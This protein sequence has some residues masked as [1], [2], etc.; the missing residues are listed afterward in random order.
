MDRSHIVDQVQYPSGRWI[1]YTPDVADRLVTIGRLT[2]AEALDKTCW[3]GVQDAPQGVPKQINLGSSLI[4]RWAFSTT[5][6]QPKLQ[7]RLWLR[8]VQQSL[9]V[10]PHRPGHGAHHEAG[11]DKLVLEQQVPR[12]VAGLVRYSYD[13]EG[14]RV[15]KEDGSVTTRYVCDANGNLAAEYGGTMAS[16]AA[17]HY[18]TTD[19]LGSTRL[20]YFGARYFSGTMG[21]FTE[22]DPVNHPTKS[23]YG[24]Q[25]FLNEPHRWNLFAYGLGN[26]LRN[27]DPDGRES[28][29]FPLFNGKSHRPVPEVSRPMTSR[30]KQFVKGMR[31]IALGIG[32]LET[33]A[34]GDIPGSALGATLVAN[35][36]IGATVTGVSGL[37]DVA[38]ATAG[39][40]VT[41]ATEVLAATSNLRGLTVTAVTGGNLDVDQAASTATSVATLARNPEAALR[42]P[43]TVAKAANTGVSAISLFSGALS[44]VAS[45]LGGAFVATPTPPRPRAPQP[46]C[47]PGRCP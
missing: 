32:L 29:S 38:G 4:E 33:A 10:R 20:E 37:V 6:Q 26:P 8:S 40:D 17:T 34:V 41:K 11:F 43:A 44:S 39:T 1:R 2:S 7:R 14:R 23:A 47:P 27:T 18:I 28:G 22:A 3:S 30:E 42:N 5:R 45:A 19:H 16:S 21:R 46:P 13:G 12:G 24:A 36:T 15:K 25:E 35:A 31:K 9:L